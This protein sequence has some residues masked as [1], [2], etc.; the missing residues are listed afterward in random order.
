MF[1]GFDYCDGIG[2]EEVCEIVF[3]YLY[4]D[5]ILIVVSCDNVFFSCFF[6]CLFLVNFIILIIFD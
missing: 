3:F 6:V 4:F 1:I 5:L 2:F